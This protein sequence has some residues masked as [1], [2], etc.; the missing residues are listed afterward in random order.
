MIALVAKGQP[1]RAE[2]FNA[3][4]S[5]VNAL[6]SGTGGAGGIDAREL[7][8]QG[9]GF[10]LRGRVKAH[11]LTGGATAALGFPEN[12]RYD[13]QLVGRQAVLEDVRPD[14]GSPVRA[15]QRVKIVPAQIGD[16]CLVARMPDGAGAYDNVLILAETLNFRT[17]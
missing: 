5:A 17:C 10:V 11:R 15:G 16:A 12:V 13:V 3:L 6:S 8:A 7:F 9:F 1:I 2:D 14:V 4:A